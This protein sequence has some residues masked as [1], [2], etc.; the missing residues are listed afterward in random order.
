MRKL[1]LAAF[2]LACAFAVSACTSTQLTT[3]SND[4][5]ALSTALNATAADLPTACTNLNAAVNQVSS[6]PGLPANI[7]TALND[8]NSKYTNY[9][10]A[11]AAIAGS[12]AA[13]VTDI[14]TFIASLAQSLAAQGN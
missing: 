3:A 14:N 8:G 2:A 13:T 10:L 11:G 7:V 5:T 9:C 12:T 1:M 6:Q 4:L